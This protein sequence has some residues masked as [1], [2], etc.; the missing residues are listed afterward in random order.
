MYHGALSRPQRERLV[1]VIRGDV[2][3][4]PFPLV[5]LLRVGGNENEQL[6][7][8]SAREEEAAAESDVDLEV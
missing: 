4:L 6:Y 3:L 7:Y 1:W 5:Y 2:V 8:D